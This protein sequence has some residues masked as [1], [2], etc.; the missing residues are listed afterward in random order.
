[1]KEGRSEEVDEKA[2][3]TGGQQKEGERR[4][5]AGGGRLQGK[6]EGSKV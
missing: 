3:R 1:M 5:L 6:R 4:A 2:R